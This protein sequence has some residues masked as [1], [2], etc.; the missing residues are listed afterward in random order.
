MN[1]SAAGPACEPSD[2]QIVAEVRGGD[3][4]RY[5][6]LIERYERKVYAIAWARLGD[7]DLAE[8][9]A[10]ETFI[11][12]YRKL[13]WLKDGA[14]FG[15]W[16]TA[17]ARHLSINLG[18]RRRHELIK[19]ER[20]AVLQQDSCVAT[21]GDEPAMAGATLQ[22]ALA[23]LPAA[24]RECLV[25]FYL[26]GKGITEAAKTLGVTPSAFK[27]RLH[28]ARQVLRRELETRLEDTLEQLRPTRPLAPAVMVLLSAPSIEVAGTSGG[29]GLLAKIGAAPLKLLPF[30]CL[31]L[32]LPIVGLIPA[33][34]LGRVEH[35]NYRDRDGFR[36][37]NYRSAMR[38]GL[39]F[40]VAIMG[41]MYFTVLWSE[42]LWGKEGLQ[43]T[44]GV[45]VL[46]VTLPLTRIL[47]LNR[48]RFIVGHFAGILTLGVG[49]IGKGFLGWPEPV[50]SLCFGG[51]FGWLAWAMRDLPMRMDYNLFLRQSQG[52]LPVGGGNTASDR[53]SVRVG[54]REMFAFARFLAER[55]LVA[56][57]RRRDAELALRLPPVRPTL[58]ANLL[59]WYWRGA[60]TVTLT[61]S[62]AIRAR[63]GERA[64][65]ELRAGP[66]PARELE[67][68][69]AQALE[70]AWAAFRDGDARACGRYL[71]E[72]RESQIFR[73]SP[74]RVIRWRR[75]LLVFAA[76]IMSIA[77]SIRWFEDRIN[78]PQFRHLRPLQVSA[79]DVTRTLAR[80][81]RPRAEERMAWRV[82]DA[83][84]M[85]IQVLP[86]R[87]L[88]TERAW[89][90]TADYIWGARGAGV[91]SKSRPSAELLGLALHSELWQKALVSE[92]LT[93]EDV[94][95]MG[96]TSS[97]LRAYIEGLALRE[98]EGLF[99]GELIRVQNESFQVLE[100]R[101]L[102]WRLQALRKLDC[103]DLVPRA[104]I[105]AAICGHQVRKGSVPEGRRSLADPK[106]V[107]GLFHTTGYDC[108]RDTYYALVCLSLLGGLDQVDQVAC[109]D[110][111]MRFHLG[112][113]MFG[114]TDGKADIGWPRG[115]AQ[116]AFFGY[117]SLRMLNALNRVTDL[118][119]WE[120]RPSNASWQAKGG[121]VE[122]V[123]T[124][125][126]IEAWQF[127]GRL[128]PYVR[129]RR[130]S[131]QTPPPT[132]LRDAGIHY[133]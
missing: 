24:H 49:M 115:D 20:W 17:I 10:Q 11:K 76:I 40:T 6:D 50:F 65:D 122:R 68:D 34:L 23:R 57:F 4:E 112:R 31:M 77:T 105:V 19:R 56:D 87:A 95:A 37:R 16:V 46:V 15:A 59:P 8:E 80:L 1:V 94:A 133:R 26:E 89:S 104:P 127:Q 28:R 51:F 113:G 48:S 99:Q 110:G 70:R 67:R 5:R 124:A 29:L 103:L 90:N 132:L 60:S 129:Q 52:M 38:K 66:E 14:K 117:E 119:R 27:T 47:A 120:F 73:V 101:W 128:Q 83:W 72:G 55:W 108:F 69:V 42:M 81:E 35:R 74:S 21:D 118:E 12:A 109:A 93:L 84:P 130:S 86:P 79:D 41:G 63:L 54:S 2:S 85:M 125:E 78:P 64:A 45:L 123:L 58:L 44:M 111:I 71:G 100:L 106:L 25:L 98:R 114:S 107:E 88:F 91:A 18:L 121:H 7:A 3:P 43:R 62:G 75:G 13:T 33:W 22:Q 9:A 32:V 92:V 36:A 96:V 102:T 30:Q 131:P 61:P 126:E 97:A 53:S 82:A 116:S 39:V